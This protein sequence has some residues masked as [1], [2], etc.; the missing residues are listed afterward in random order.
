MNMV[1]QDWRW[2]SEEQVRESYRLLIGLAG[3]AQ[4]AGLHTRFASEQD[5]MLPELKQVRSTHH[6]LVV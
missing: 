2:S 4:D 5:R 1:P 6:A 3:K